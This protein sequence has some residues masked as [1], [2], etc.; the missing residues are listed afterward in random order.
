MRTASEGKQGKSPKA[1]L[2]AQPSPIL[3]LFRRMAVDPSGSVMPIGV[4]GLVLIL[5]MGGAAVDFSRAYMAQS[6]LQA[7]CDAGALAGRR[8][9]SSQGF[10]SAANQT[11]QDYFSA[12]FNKDADQVSSFEASFSSSDS[13]NTV[14]GVASGEVKTLV[15]KYTTIDDI[16]ISTECTATM[17]VGNSDVTMVLDTTGSMA[18]TRIAALKTAMK[19][20]Y[21]TVDTATQGSNARIRYA[22]VPY[23]SAVN[24]GNVLYDTDPSFLL[25]TVAIQS[26]EP[27]YEDREVEHFDHWGPAQYSTAPGGT[28]STTYGTWIKHSN[29]AYSSSN[30]CN[31][32]KPANGAW[33]NSGSASQGTRT[34][35]NPSGQQVTTTTTTQPQTATVYQCTRYPDRKYYIQTTTASRDSYSYAYET[36]DPVN[37]IDIERVFAGFTYKRVNWDVSSYK[38]GGTLSYLDDSGDEQTTTWDGCVGERKTVYADQF[39]YSNMLGFTPAGAIDLEIDAGSE[40]SSDGKWAPMVGPVAYLRGYYRN[41]SFR[42]QNVAEYTSGAKPGSLFYVCPNRSRLLDEMTQSEFYAFANGLSTGGSTWHDIG[43]IWGGRVS[44]PDGIFADVVNEEPANGGE[45]ARHLIFMTDGEMNADNLVYSSYGIEF[46]DKRTTSDGST[47]AD[48]I[49]TSRFLAVCEAI[50]SKGIRLWV[51]AFGTGLTA[52]LTTC[53]SNQSA[54][55]ATNAAELN[56]SFQ[57]IAKQVGELRITQ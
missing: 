45:V 54:F 21:D 9:V 15:L 57:E 52:D 17:S 11:A 43:A 34:E 22:F 3:A 18:G 10:D 40:S 38:S 19:N 29:T 47:N 5:L 39:A 27:L 50:R 55:T 46:H 14:E 56:D 49:H 4:I 31:N 1:G 26:R 33:S 6:R 36:R 20:F 35:I 8:S 25:D 24:I 30:S 44:S 53:A 37:R 13:G 32:A 2:G 16:A 28:S 7:A 12:N 41:G 23:S 51:I 48:Q 42:P